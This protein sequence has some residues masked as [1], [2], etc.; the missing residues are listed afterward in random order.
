MT[1]RIVAGVSYL[2]LVLC[3]SGCESSDNKAMESPNTDMRAEFAQR[4]TNPYLSYEHSLSIELEHNALASK[5]KALTDHCAADRDNNCTILESELS[6]G[7][8]SYGKI[9]IR[10]APTGVEAFLKLAGDSGEI[11]TESTNVE[12]LSTQILDTEKRIKLLQT[13]QANLLELQTQAKGDIDSLIKV[14]QE[15]ANVQSQLEDLNGNSQALM[16]RVNMDI[17]NIR[18]SSHRENSFWQPIEDALE[19]FKGNFAD[20]IASAITV[21]AYLIP[22]LILFIV[23][24]V[25][26]R[27]FWKKARHQKAK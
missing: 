1:K 14:S 25:V 18:L 8:Y 22:W 10:I 4:K 26:I 12:D 11:T 19:E 20:G 21:T 24:L 2:L 27:F 7:N 17:V 15:I 9:R 5:Y 3:L 16:Q 6:A 13:Y 23:V